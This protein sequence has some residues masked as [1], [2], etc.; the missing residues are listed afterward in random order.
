MILHFIEK[1][2]KTFPVNAV[3]V[4]PGSPD[5]IFIGTTGLVMYSKDGGKAGSWEKL[6]SYQML[7]VNGKDYKG[8]HVSCD[9]RKQTGQK[10]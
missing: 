4:R 9:G 1:R 6:T 3:V 10:A 5:E 2:V 7:S 8:S